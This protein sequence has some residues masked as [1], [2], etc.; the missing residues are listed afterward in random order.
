MDVRFPRLRPLR[1]RLRLGRPQRTALLA[2]L[3]VAALFPTA[4]SGDDIIVQVADGTNVDV[5][6][7]VLSSGPH[8]LTL[9]LQASGSA[10][11]IY[12]SWVNDPN[13]TILWTSNDNTSAG[14]EHHWT[15]NGVYGYNV[16]TPT[17]GGYT[18]DPSDPMMP[19][20]IFQVAVSH[21]D[22]DL[23]DLSGDPPPGPGQPDLKNEAESTTGVGMPVTNNVADLPDTFPLSDDTGRALSVNIISGQGGTLLFEGTSSQLQVYRNNGSVWEKVTAGL[24]VSAGSYGASFMVHTSSQFTGPVLLKARLVHATSALDAADEVKVLYAPSADLDGD[25]DNTTPFTMYPDQANLDLQKDEDD[26]E[27]SSPLRI[28]INWGD[29]DN[30]MVP[31]FADGINLFGNGQA[32]SCG[33]FAPIILSLLKAGDTSS[34]TI[35]FRYP[36]S[37][38]AGVTRIQEPNGGGD[39]YTYTP[40]VGNLRIWT[41]DGPSVRNVA[42][43]AAGGHYVAPD[44]AYTPQQLGIVDGTVRLYLEA[45]D[46]VWQGS[47]HTIT[48][49]VDP[50]GPGPQPVVPDTIQV[51]TIPPVVPENPGGSASP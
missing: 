37:D 32:G 17:F 18:D 46:D 20:G 14:F 22:M 40:A 15:A 19:Y 33:N 10:S 49:E 34:A 43:V 42:T 23:D 50:D 48:V 44:V 3:L 13:G 7:D 39:V 35:T 2:L 41:Q 36:G 9:T 11:T 47:T 4:F 6:F 29:Q 31:G 27:D 1:F 12:Y 26:I 30:D 5:G 8:D 24:P 45:A 21:L 38:P 25:S 16:T 28:D 51:E